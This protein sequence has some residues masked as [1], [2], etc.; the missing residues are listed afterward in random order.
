MG[1]RHNLSRADKAGC[2]LLDMMGHSSE[3]AV[4]WAVMVAELV[5]LEQVCLLAELV[6][7]S[8]LPKAPHHCCAQFLGVERT[9]LDAVHQADRWQLGRILAG[10]I[11]H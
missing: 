8:A 7:L 6:Y 1:F 3:P 9:N 4:A 11:Q 10:P 5:G 2:I